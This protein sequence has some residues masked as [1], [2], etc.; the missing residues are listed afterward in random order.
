MHTFGTKERQD[1]FGIN[2]HDF[3]AR[4]SDPTIGNRFLQQDLLAEISRRFSPYIYANSNP[5]NFIDPDGLTSRTIY[6]LEGKAHEIGDDEVSNVYTAPQEG[7]EKEKGV[8]SSKPPQ[9]MMIG[10]NVYKR[11]EDGT[12]QVE[13][14]GITP[15]Y[16]LESTVISGKILGPLFG[17]LA[18]I[19]GFGSK[20][21]S[22]S[23]AGKYG[24]NSYSTLRTTVID[25]LGKG[26]GMEVHH[27]IEQR[28]A[29]LLG[30]NSNNMLSIVVTRTEHDIFSV[31]TESQK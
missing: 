11:Q 30:Q 20:F 15:D 18:T 6:D 14:N 5:L 16:T 4:F 31:C 24:I 2:L 25:Q 21:G 13:P 3:E 27:L 12:Y 28:F 23:V 1:D 29:S 19:L 10:Q 9:S 17:K 26:S 22:L 8:T 7:D